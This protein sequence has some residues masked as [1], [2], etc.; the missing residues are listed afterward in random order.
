MQDW[1]LDFIIESI[2]HIEIVEDITQQLIFHL[3]TYSAS[4]KV[5]LFISFSVLEPNDESMRI[6]FIWG[7]TILK[8]IKIDL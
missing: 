2:K 5:N 3:I 1:G 6:G 8:K 7:S 4:N